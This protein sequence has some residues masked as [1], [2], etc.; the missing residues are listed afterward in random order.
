MTWLL[1]TK[2]RPE[3][4]KRFMRAAREMGTST[5]GIVLVNADDKTDYREAMALAPDGW[6]LYVVPAAK[7]YGDALRWVWDAVKDLPWVGLVSDDLVPCTPNW[8]KHLLQSLTGWNFVSSN[9]GWQAP[10]RMH[11]AVAWSGELLRAVGWLFPEGLTH[12]FHDDMWETIGRETG[13][14]QVRMEVM[15]KHLHES[16]GGTIGPTM[17]TQSVL[18]LGDAARYETWTLGGEKDVAIAAVKALMAEKQVIAMKPDFAGVSLMIGVPAIDGKYE[19]A[20]VAGVFQTFEAMKQQGVVCHLAEE[21]YTADISLGRAKIF[22]AF[23]RSGASHL[24]M[25]DADM[26]WEV[27]AVFRLFCA[28]KDFVAI[29]GPKKRY[30]LQFAAN[31]TDAAGNPI[32]L[33]YDTASGTMEVSEVGSA[34]ALITRAMAEKLVRCY[35]E[36]EY[37]GISGESE[38]A[39][40]NPMVQARRYYSEDFA[41]CRRWRDIGGAVHIV[42][43]VNL[44]HTGA[45]QF[46]GNFLQTAMAVKEGATMTRLADAAE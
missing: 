38:W 21:K 42:P 25:I 20:F 37:V 22:A 24:L 4:L 35:P 7:T 46:K 31:H 9:D 19:S 2:G 15:V 1:P 28:K 14:W 43:D 45:H 8:D 23:L 5:P 30:P 36:L 27:E 13:C 17:D 34:F 11:G 40:F 12:V 26:G 41:F 44:T 3:N 6:L 18:W 10:R 29:A 33:V 16:L 39:V 32:N